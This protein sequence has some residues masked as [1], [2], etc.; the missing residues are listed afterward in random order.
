MHY[1][2][3]GINKIL[4]FIF[5]HWCS[6]WRDGVWSL[7]QLLFVIIWDLKRSPL[8]CCVFKYYLMSLIKD[9]AFCFFIYISFIFFFLL[10]FNNE[11]LCLSTYSIHTR[12]KRSFLHGIECCY[13]VG[14]WLTVPL[15]IYRLIKPTNSANTTHSNG[16]LLVNEHLLIRWADAACK[17]FHNNLC[18][19][20][21]V[22]LDR[23]AE[24]PGLY[25]TWPV[26]SCSVASAVCNY[27]DCCI[28]LLSLMRRCS[29]WNSL[30]L[31]TLY[32]C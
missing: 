5:T 1:S 22:L 18:W 29:A 21:G 31:R 28:W 19:L 26:N 27:S 10:L 24:I 15:L 4:H 8:W 11:G 23:W 7:W 17:A 14:I 6:I 16:N 9:H 12:L 25:E 13:E 3:C 20:L 30:D 2:L 32:F